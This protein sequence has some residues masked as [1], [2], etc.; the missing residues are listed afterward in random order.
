MSFRCFLLIAVVLVA[1][2][3]SAQAVVLSFTDESAYN[4]AVGSQLFFIDFNG[5]PGGVSAGNFVGQVDFGS[6]EAED[7]TQVLYGSDAL[8]DAGSTIATNY[9]GPVDGLF[10]TPVSAFGLVFLSSGNP[11]TLELYD[12]GTSLVGTAV[13]NPGGFFGVVSSIPVASFI[14]RNGEFSPGNR[15]RF[16]VDDFRANTA[17][18]EPGSLLL[19]G[20]ALLA[21]GIAYRRRGK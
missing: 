15:D 5:L 17:V 14:I 11:Q 18:P 8:T 21:L 1:M 10:A 3:T 2:T 4:A 16:F 20:P 13:S 7:P 12:A 6:P 19:F 9:V